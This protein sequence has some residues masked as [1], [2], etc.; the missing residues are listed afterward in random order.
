MKLGSI[1]RPG[2]GQVGK[3]LFG[4]GL[5]GSMPT[6]V[7]KRGKPTLY[8]FCSGT[9]K[10]LL[11]P[12]INGSVHNSLSLHAGNFQGSDRVHLLFIR[13]FFSFSLSL[14][15]VWHGPEYS[16]HRILVSE[17]NRSKVTG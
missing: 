4:N 3:K 9:A 13:F 10:C 5:E 1:K 16:L 8:A 15:L 11:A 2:S 14:S 6:A 12:L 17:L 7:M